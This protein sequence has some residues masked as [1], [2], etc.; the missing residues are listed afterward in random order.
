MPQIPDYIEERIRR[1]IPAGLSVIEGS[2]PVVAFGNSRK[3]RVATLGLNPSRLEFQDNSGKELTGASRRLATHKSL[4]VSDLANAPMSAIE[5]VL[6]DC[7]T[8]FERNP[9]WQW[10]RDLE[11]VLCQCGA[12]FRDGS[13]C[14]LDLV[15]WATDPTWGELERS[16]HGRMCQK[17]LLN[18]DRE[19]LRAQLTRE[20]IALVLVNGSG[21][22]KRLTAN[23]GVRFQQ[24][25]LTNHK[26]RK[27]PVE[28]CTARLFGSVRVITWNTN[29]QS[30]RPTPTPQVK[31]EIAERVGTL[32]CS[33]SW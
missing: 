9:Y 32:S 6:Q 1:R 26:W 10:F 29:L 20:N 14:H 15:Q 30:S 13:A 24:A 12:S 28:I 8:Y 3:A 19:F 33:M 22:S 11:K 25:A 27:R 17:H 4:G 31:V 23:Y 5:Q 16:P 7:D 21:V 18:S 2:T